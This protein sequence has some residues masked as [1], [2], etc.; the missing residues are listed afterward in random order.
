VWSFTEQTILAKFD[1]VLIVVSSI[2]RAQTTSKYSYALASAAGL[3]TL[4]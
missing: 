4:T 2:T 3:V 1:A